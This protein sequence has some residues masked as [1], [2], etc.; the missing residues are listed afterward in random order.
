MSKEQVENSGD[1]AH[2]GRQVPAD[3]TD[4][5]CPHTVLGRG[6]E[7]CPGGREGRGL[8]FQDQKIQETQA[9]L[10]ALVRE[11]AG[12]SSKSLLLQTVALYWYVCSVL[13]TTISGTAVGQLV[14]VNVGYPLSAT[15]HC[16]ID[17]SKGHCI[18]VWSVG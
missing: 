2:Q 12:S 16:N 18:P 3:G 14:D 4:S 5:R 8:Q 13:Q 1:L 15:K 17:Y 9:R 7:R 6:D 11:V 10:Q